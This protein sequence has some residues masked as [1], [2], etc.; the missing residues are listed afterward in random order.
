VRPELV[1][2]VGFSGW[3]RENLLRQASFAGLRED[4]PAAAVVREEAAAPEPRP[5]QTLG[6]RDASVGDVRLTHPDRLVWPDSGITKSDLAHYCE[7]VARWLLPQLDKRPL[8]LLRCPDGSAAECFF[9]KHLGRQRPLGVQN[10]IWE[11][12]SGATRDY[13]YVDSIE[14]VIGLV[15]RGIVEFHTW[16]SRLPD[17]SRPD[18]I[19][20]DLDPAPDVPWPRVAEGAHLARTLLE[21][22][23]LVCFLKTTG[24]K[25]LHVVA[26][27]ER[28]QGWDE[29]KAFTRA[30]ARHLAS[31]LPDR[32]TANMA[33]SRRGGRIFVDYLRNDE[34]ATAIAA[35]ST[36]A[37]PGAPV[38]VPL[39]WDEL[40]P[41]LDPADWN[42]KTVPA[43]LADRRDPWQG[44]EE[45][46]RAITAKMR[47]ALGME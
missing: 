40:S 13:A 39:S 18:R 11:E 12:A 44:Y 21:E 2:E 32:F 17:P 6:S 9:Q 3:T 5:A 16:G 8:S 22:L 35:Y 20:I 47:R 10:F 29:V 30:I 37:R 38:S 25:G 23:G 26:P 41:D 36:R 33:K 45:S 7:S 1:A 24:G 31:V 43:R 34:G 46:T 15:Q 28:R 27:I 19:T 42:L 14:A 4:K